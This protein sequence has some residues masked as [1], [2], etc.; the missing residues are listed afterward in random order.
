M[1]GRDQGGGGSSGAESGAGRAR[2]AGDRQ[3]G[4]RDAEQPGGSRPLSDRQSD[5]GGSGEDPAAG[6]IDHPIAPGE[7]Q[8]G[9]LNEAAGNLGGPVDVFPLRERSRR[10]RPPG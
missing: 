1:A 3:G 8:A 7:A 2:M 4:P 6:T 5:P 9:D 10:E